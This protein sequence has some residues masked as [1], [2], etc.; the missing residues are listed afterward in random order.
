MAALTENALIEY[1]KTGRVAIP[2]KGGVEIF[3]GAHVNVRAGYAV[4]AA[5]TAGDEYAGFAEEPADNTDGSDGDMTVLVNTT[6]E[7]LCTG[8]GFAQTDVGQDVFIEDDATVAL[9]AGVTNL[10]KVGQITEFKSTT[11]VW[12]DQRRA[13]LFV[14]AQEVADPAAATSTNNT[15]ATAVPGA[16][17]ST[18]GTAAAAVPGALTSTDGTA[19]AAAADLAALAAEAEKIGDD[20]RDVHAA[21]LLAQAETEKIGDDV[22]AIHAADLLAQAEA[23]KIGDDVRALRTTLAAVVTALKAQGVLIDP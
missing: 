1:R 2:V 3:K 4:P 20:V 19:A 13:R 8:V 12:V 5:D 14:V 23:E 10:V 21:M 15:A 17:T 16:L 7:L 6:D 22:R 11:E 18:D 9:A